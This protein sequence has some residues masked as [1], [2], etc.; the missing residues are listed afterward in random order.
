MCCQCGYAA[1]ICECPNLLSG[2]EVVIPLVYKSEPSTRPEGLDLFA[3]YLER[4]PATRSVDVRKFVSDYAKE[5]QAVDQAATAQ[6]AKEGRPSRLKYDKL[7]GCGAC[8]SKPSSCVWSYATPK[9]ISLLWEVRA[10]LTSRQLPKR[11]L[12]CS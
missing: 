1:V 6:Y 8:R 10:F 9:K 11:Q 2:Q 7:S 4:H 5:M 12:P 3:T